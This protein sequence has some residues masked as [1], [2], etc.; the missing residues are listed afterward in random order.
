M[1]ETIIW[2]WLELIHVSD[3]DKFYISR[4]HK[5]FFLGIDDKNGLSFNTLEAAKAVAEIIKKDR[6]HG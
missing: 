3:C 1:K 4:F 5:L 6:N 2:T